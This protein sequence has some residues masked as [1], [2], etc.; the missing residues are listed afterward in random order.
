MSRLTTSIAALAVLVTAATVNGQDFSSVKS[1]LLV[2]VYASPSN[3]G[4]R[5]SDTIPGYSAEGRL[6]PGDVLLRTTFDG[7]QVFRLRSH[8]EMENAKMAIGPNREAAM[9]IWRPG[10]GLIYAWVEFT[11]IASPT[12]TYGAE[13]PCKAQ[14]RMESEKPGARMMF[15]QG[16]NGGG[17]PSAP[18]PK[19][20]GRP[21]NMNPGSLF[22]N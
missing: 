11:P 18:L 17:R 5:V 1:G 13:V 16:S 9:E 15:Q 2:G 10:V 14:F 20:S 8:Y 4:M 19:P 7:V 22:G 6:F 3:G 21:G 12:A